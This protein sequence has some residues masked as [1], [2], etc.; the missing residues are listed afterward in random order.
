MTKNL[1]WEILTKNLITFKGWDG[2]N[3]EKFSC[4]GSSLKDPIYRGGGRCVKKLVLGVGV[5]NWL[6][7]GAWIVCRFKR[8]LGKK[9]K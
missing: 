8:G 9:E 7:R 6:K 4:H 3:N 2:V 5:M 1:N